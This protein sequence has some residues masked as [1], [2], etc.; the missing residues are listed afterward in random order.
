VFASRGP[1]KGN[2]LLI[3]IIVVICYIVIKIVN[4]NLT[5]FIFCVFY[6]ISIFSRNITFNCLCFGYC[7]FMFQEIFDTC[8][9]NDK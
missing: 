7:M 1:V 2:I 4:N 5:Q 9:I 6:I 8:K 3:N